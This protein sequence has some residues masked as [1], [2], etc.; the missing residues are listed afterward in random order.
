M[1][2]AS[3]SSAVKGAA[4]STWACSRTATSAAARSSVSGTAGGSDLA[5]VT[6]TA[7]MCAESFGVFLEGTLAL[8]FVILLLRPWKAREACL[9][10]AAPPDRLLGAIVFAELILYRDLSS[11]RPRLEFVVKSMQVNRV[12]M[13]CYL[14]LASSALPSTTVNA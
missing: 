11:V 1:L 12:V 3:S 14:A 7:S 5:S 9:E 10:V 8:G 6:V 2:F 4:A 13:E